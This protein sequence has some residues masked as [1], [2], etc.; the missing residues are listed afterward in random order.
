MMIQTNDIA[1]ILWHIAVFYGVRIPS[2]LVFLSQN[3]QL[4]Y[5]RFHNFFIFFYKKKQLKKNCK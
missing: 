3:H 4:N 1:A 2:S 5:L